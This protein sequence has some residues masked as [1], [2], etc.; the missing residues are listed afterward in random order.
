MWV[1]DLPLA[2]VPLW[3]EAQPVVMPAWLILAPVNVVVLVWQVSQA[4]CVTMWVFDLPLA[5]VP[6]WQEAQPVV[7]PAWLILAPVN[8]V[9]LVWQVSQAAVRHDVGLRLALGRRAVVA[10]GAA[11]RDAGVA[12]LGA[13]ERRRAGVAGLARRRRNDMRRPICPSPSPRCGKRR[14][15]R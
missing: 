2:V 9:V 11:G 13:E 7:M 15:R 14:S 4:A 10:G 3:Q 5:V 6:L 8:V 1:F 12:H